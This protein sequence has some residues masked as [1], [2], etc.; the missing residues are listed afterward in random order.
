[1]NDLGKQ[2]E[3]APKNLVLY[4]LGLVGAVVDDYALV[5]LLIFCV[6]L[7][8]VLGSI[9]IPATVFFGAYFVLRMVVAIV[10]SITAHGSATVH[11]GNQIAGALM[12]PHQAQGSPVGTV[13]EGDTLP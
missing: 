3:N 7:G 12:Y 10:N 5:T 13:V 2:L 9:L 6:L 4:A 11:A 8:F 1:M